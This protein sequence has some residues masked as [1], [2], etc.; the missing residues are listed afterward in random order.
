MTRSGT[1]SLNR[2]GWPMP[3]PLGS[4]AYTWPLYAAALVGYL[5][6]SIPFGLLLS[7]LA[8]LGDIRNIGSGNIGATNV[9]RTG[10]KG[11][12][13]ATLFLDAGKGA[14][15]V[16]LAQRYGTDMAVMAAGGAILGHCF[17]IWL[18]FRGGKGVATGIGILFALAPVVGLLSCCVWLILA[19]VFRYSSLASLGAFASAPV[20]AYKLI[21]LQHA[22]IAGFLTIV[23]VLRH[24]PNIVRLLKG[25]EGRLSLSGHKKPD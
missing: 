17:P 7:R 12:A 23:I 19:A 25:E 9:L 22:E 10:R 11:I 4:L 18:R 24:F 14:V 16:L 21:D 15:A 6:G 3:D 2:T 20:A 13:A 1:D 8:G 5:L